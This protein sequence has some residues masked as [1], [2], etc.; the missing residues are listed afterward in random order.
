MS[1]LSIISSYCPEISLKNARYGLQIF[2]GA[3]A[4]LFFQNFFQNPSK[5]ASLE[6]LTAAFAHAYEATTSYE[7][8]HTTII[9][10]IGLNIFRLGV[11]GYCAGHSTISNELNMVDAMIHGVNLISLSSLLIQRNYIKRMS[12]LNQ[13]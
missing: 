10:A 2:N 6:Y 1:A 9:T 7:S 3:A 8:D 13:K 12:F 11:I 5:D 4:G